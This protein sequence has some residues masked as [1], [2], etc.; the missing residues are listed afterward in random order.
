M[1]KLVAEQGSRRHHV[2]RSVA[3]HLDLRQ[4]E[5]NDVLQQVEVRLAAS[6]EFPEPLE[7]VCRGRAAEVEAYGGEHGDL[8]GQDLLFCVCV[9]S[10]VD[11]V[12][13]LRGV[14]L[15]ELRSYQH[16]CH[17]HELKLPPGHRPEA[18]VAVDQVYGQEECLSLKPVLQ[19]D[20]YEPVY[21][22]GPHFGIDL[23]LP[24]HAVGFGHVCALR[25][26][27]TPVDVWDVLEAGLWIFYLL[28]AVHH[29]I[30]GRRLLRLPAVQQ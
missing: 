22:D 12:P 9:V 20:L 27:E 6:V 13:R 5:F 30:G 15:F 14:D 11:E 3:N 21:Q 28:L 25:F 17:T 26:A 1:Q 8:H 19:V 16:P 29:H 4:G 10:D 23:R 7:E 2:G 24:L 18:H